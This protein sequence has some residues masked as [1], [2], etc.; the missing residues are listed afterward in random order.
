MVADHFIAARVSSDTKTRLKSMAAQRQLSE[1][2]LLKDLLDLT[3]GGPAVPEPA[4]PEPVAR[5]ARD[6]RLYVRL[7]LDDQLL[8]AERGRGAWRPPRMS[9]CWCARTSDS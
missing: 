7:R 5:V 2:A 4:D 9:R 6:A 8:L 3:L 1:S